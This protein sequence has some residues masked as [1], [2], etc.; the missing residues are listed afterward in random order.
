MLRRRGATAGGFPL[1]LINLS[2]KL[3]SDPV[4]GWALSGRLAVAQ[5]SEQFCEL[6]LRNTGLANERAEGAFGQLAVVGNGQAP[7]GRLAQDDVAP[8]L[9]I[10]F[11]AEFSKGFNPRLRRNRRA[12]GSYRNFDDFLADRTGNRLTV[13]V[14]AVEVSLDGVLNILYRFVSGLALRNASR[15]HRTFRHE[16]AVFVMLNEHSELHSVSIVALQEFRNAFS[17]AS[18]AAGWRHQRSVFWKGGKVSVSVNDNVIFWTKPSE[19][20]TTSLT[21][22][23]FFLPAAEVERAGETPGL[24]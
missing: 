11:I 6:L 13:F 19:N 16:D 20:V 9:M 22:T 7:A 1:E 3:R 2:E 17:Y 23:F 21:D 8:G 4:C 18:L 14:Q 10:D 5:E 12:S 24:L 15:Q